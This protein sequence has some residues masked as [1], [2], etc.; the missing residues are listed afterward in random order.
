MNRSLDLHIMRHINAVTGLGWVAGTDT[1]VEFTRLQRTRFEKSCR[2][3]K[4]LHP[5]RTAGVA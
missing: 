2:R 5:I 4:R 3:A 1:T